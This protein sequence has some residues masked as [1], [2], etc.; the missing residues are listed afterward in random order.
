MKT[1]L[2]EE[3]TEQ[4]TVT[5]RVN[6]KLIRMQSIHDPFVRTK[7]TLKGFKHAWN[8]LFGGLAV[9]VSVDGSP[10]ELAAEEE[11]NEDIR[12]SGLE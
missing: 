1:H 6:Q 10:G 8:A 12:V 5:T 11:Y 4:F 2:G 9:E 3:G 7:V